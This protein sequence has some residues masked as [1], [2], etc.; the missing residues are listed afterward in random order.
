M[1]RIVHTSFLLQRQAATGGRLGTIHFGNGGK[2]QTPVLFPAICIMTGPPGFGRQGSHYKYIKRIMCREWR[3]NHF[4]SEILHFT[5]YMATPESLDMWL[6]KPFQLWMD[7][8][9]RGGD[10]KSKDKGD[11]SDYKRGDP[12]EAGFF[13]DSGA[14]KLAWN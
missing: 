5:D 3:H 6:C 7:A 12:Y 2:V 14:F 1:G 4:L 8:M 13:L 11:D 9:M 10:A